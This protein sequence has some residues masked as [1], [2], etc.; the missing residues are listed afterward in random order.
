[1]DNL[2]VVSTAFLGMSATAFGDTFALNPTVVVTPRP[3]SGLMLPSC[4]V[5]NAAS[6]RLRRALI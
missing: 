2:L 5:A 4:L 3:A 6:G 1:M